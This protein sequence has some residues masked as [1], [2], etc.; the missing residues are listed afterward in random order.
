MLRKAVRLFTDIEFEDHDK[1]YIIKKK[2]RT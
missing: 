1:L 2:K